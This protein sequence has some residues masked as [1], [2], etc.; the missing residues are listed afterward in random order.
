MYL[1]RGLII[2]L[3]GDLKDSYRFVKTCSSDYGAVG[4]PEVVA[5]GD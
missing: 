5:C 3:E 2:D 4:A 1:D